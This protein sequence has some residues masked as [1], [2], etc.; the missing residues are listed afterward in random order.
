MTQNILKLLLT[1]VVA[2][3][4]S[5]QASQIHVSLSGDDKN[6]G[7]KVKPVRT[8][9]AARDKVRVLR[10][11]GEK[12][13]VR[14]MIHAGVYHLDET[15]ILSNEDSAPQ[16]AKTIYRAATDE[17][18]VLS[19]GKMVDGWRRLET[20]PDYLPAVAHGKVWVAELPW[21]TPETR[22]HALML[23]G[24]FMPRARGEVPSI[25]NREKVPK[26][27]HINY[28]NLMKYR[29]EFAY[30][31]GLRDWP[32]LEDIELFK[33][34]TR[35]WLVNYIPLGEVDTEK[36]EAR[37]S[38]PAT[39]TIGKGGFIENAIDFLDEPGEW[40][41]NTREKKLYYW[42]KADHPEPGI[43]AT[44]LD[45]VIRV[46]GVS[47]ASLGGEKEKPVRGIVFKGLTFS[48]A[49]RQRIEPDDIG[50]QHDW[51][52]WDKDNGLIRFRS[53][54]DCIVRECAFIDSGSDGVRMDLF[55]QGITVTHSRFDNLGG[56]GVLLSGYGPGLKDVN[57]SNV[58]SENIITR[59]GQLFWHSPAIFISQSG[60]NLI[61]KNHIHELGYTGIVVSGVR[62]RLYARLFGE[63][64]YLKKW[65]FPEGTREVMNGF[66][67]D[68][69]ELK[70]GIHEW[71]SFEPFA[72]ARGNIIEYNEVHDCMKI[73][74]D[75]N[76]IYLSANGDGNIVRHN[77]LYNHPHGAHLRTYDDSHGAIISGNLV[78]ANQSDMG[79][80]I[81]GLNVA[82]NNI[83]VNGI[84]TTGGAGNTCDPE[85]IMQRNVLYH[86]LSREEPGFFH[87]LPMLD[88]SLDSNLY[89]HVD[90]K[91][92]EAKFACQQSDKSPNRD[93]H[94]L[95]ADPLFANMEKGDFSFA[96]GSPAERLG[97][98]SFPAD[99]L[100]QVAPERDP[101]IA[102]FLEN[103]RHLVL[104]E[105]G[106]VISKGRSQKKL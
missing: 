3:T 44:V 45:E 84:L 55:C 103:H 37:L 89:W 80:Q 50:I 52:M 16:G 56:V 26:N 28:L 27:G 8:L 104:P 106:Y 93:K 58:I 100:N 1:I 15:L 21:V 86:T 46:E 74:H 77:V 91:I 64:Q 75:G 68:E 54:K 5:V 43:L 20:A 101:F 85:T 82:T 72:H 2:A 92:G 31:E 33:Q 79:I 97:I 71:S 60:K 29:F 59:T 41:L 19:G 10:A 66:R 40:V 24:G 34:P 30:D 67:W 7:S 88:G 42:P 76:A 39:Y 38:V 12:G 90:L 63:D 57:H 81:K 62:R 69:I 49:D 73:L 32:N 65:Y 9:K 18:V 22:F 23:D 61:R 51:D 13:D 48:H 105:E 87:S 36:K 47:D 4:A 70:D 96:E 102:R 11:E 99:F 78:F 83:L 95:L 53:A 25:R 94:S 6:P 98:E 35:L 14:V 17:K